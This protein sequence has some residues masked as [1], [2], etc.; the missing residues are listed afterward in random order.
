MLTLYRYSSPVNKPTWKC[1]E[2]T[3][4]PYPLLEVHP[5][6]SSVLFDTAWKKKL[7]ICEAYA[8]YFRGLE[9]LSGLLLVMQYAMKRSQWHARTDTQ[10]NVSS[11]KEMN[12]V[13][14]LLLRQGDYRLSHPQ[15]LTLSFAFF[16]F[17]LC[18]FCSSL[19]VLFLLLFFLNGSTN[20]EMVNSITQV[21]KGSSI[22]VSLPP[23]WT[24]VLS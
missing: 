9:L 10:T 18:F 17:R 8:K 5:C 15:I 11:E 21:R 12:N 16:F 3:F 20:I 2:T 6:V 14:D 7:L 19:P 4:T 22:W 1:P 13:P 23:R 24:A